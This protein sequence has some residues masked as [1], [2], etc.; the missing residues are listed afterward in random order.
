MHKDPLHF[1]EDK[2]LMVNCQGLIVN[3]QI[4]NF[5]LNIQLSDVI[6][7]RLAVVNLP[8]TINH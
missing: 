5:Y 4:C 8:L 3:A 1:R 6:G 2:F 7:T